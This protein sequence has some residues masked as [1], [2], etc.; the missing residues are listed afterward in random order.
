[1]HA[2]KITSDLVHVLP[3]TRTT[4]CKGSTKTRF[5]LELGCHILVFL[6]DTDWISNHIQCGAMEVEQYSGGCAKQYFIKNLGRRVRQEL[7]TGR[8]LQTPIPCLHLP[9]NCQKFVWT[10]KWTSHPFKEVPR[11][12]TWAWK[13]TAG[14]LVSPSQPSPPAACSSSS[15]IFFNY[16]GLPC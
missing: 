7:L 2:T 10:N 12:L 13:G 9:P 15:C 16:K 3:C 5:L 6:L 1:M 8:L 14:F 4:A 11:L